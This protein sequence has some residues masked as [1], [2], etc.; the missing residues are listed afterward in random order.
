M[1]TRGDIMED[2]A[3]LWPEGD[4]DTGRQLIFVELVLDIRDLLS[5]QRLGEWQRCPN[6]TCTAGRVYGDDLEN[7]QPMCRICGG[8]GVIQRPPVPDC[9]ICP[10][11]DAK[12]L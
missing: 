6:P 1:R 3:R 4:R 12:G 9:G 8:K 2:I 10:Q 11:G 5:Q 7:Y